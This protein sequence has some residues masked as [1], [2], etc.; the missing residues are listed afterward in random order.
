L[1]RAGPQ[2]RGA[3]PQDSGSRAGGASTRRGLHQISRGGNDIT[4]ATERAKR[5]LPVGYRFAPVVTTMGHNLNQH[6]GAHDL[7]HPIARWIAAILPS[8]TG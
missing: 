1:L 8:Q 6:P 3:G 5:Q 4:A 2:D 7:Y